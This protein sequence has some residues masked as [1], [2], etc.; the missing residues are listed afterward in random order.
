MA[1]QERQHDKLRPDSVSPCQ[2]AQAVPSST[3]EYPWVDEACRACPGLNGLNSKRL[4]AS[5]SIASCAVK[6]LVECCR[7]SGTSN[8]VWHDSP[9]DLPASAFFSFIFNS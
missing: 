2:R 5:E 9:S 8:A 6:T 4:L 1:C 3:S 7:G